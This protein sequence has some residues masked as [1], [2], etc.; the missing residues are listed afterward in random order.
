M[1]LAGKFISMDSM[2]IMTKM[3]NIHFFAPQ[4]KSGPA[5]LYEISAG[6]TIKLFLDQTGIK[7]LDKFLVLVNGR[8][9]KPETELI[10]SDILSI[11]VLLAGG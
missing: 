1:G 8:P 5:V 3:I 11:V 2:S 10:D 7:D 6:T 4:I 9:S